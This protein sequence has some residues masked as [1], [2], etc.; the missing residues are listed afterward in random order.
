MALR[1][2]L[3]EARVQVWFQNRRAKWRKSEKIDGKEPEVPGHAYEAHLIDGIQSCSSTM[4]CDTQSTVP[5][6]S[7]LELDTSKLLHLESNDERLSPNL[8]LNLNFDHTNTMD[9]NNLKFEWSSSFNPTTSSASILSPLPSKQQTSSSS[10][11]SNSPTYEFID[12]FN[13]DNFKNECILNL[14]QN[15]VDTRNMDLQS[16]SMHDTKELL[17]LEKPININVNSL[18]N[19]KY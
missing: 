1:I 2:E 6:Q 15:F 9:S 16:F 18:D 11:A 13:I 19:D 7:I 14:D 12:H 10:F 3:T 4:L 5:Q 17:D 8:F